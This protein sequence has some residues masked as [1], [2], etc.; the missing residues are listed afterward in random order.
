MLTL[1]AS[2]SDVGCRFGFRQQH[3]GSSP[4]FMHPSWERTQLWIQQVSSM[5]DLGSSRDVLAP[6]ALGLLES[7]PVPEL[8]ESLSNTALKLYSAEAVKLGDAV[9]SLSAAHKGSLRRV[10]SH[11]EVDLRHVPA[12]TCWTERTGDHEMALPG[13]L[14]TMDE[15][16]T[17][18]LV[19]PILGAG[20]HIVSFDSVTKAHF[21]VTSRGR[22]FTWVGTEHGHVNTMHKDVGIGDALTRM[23]PD[24][25]YLLRS[26]A[27][28]TIRAVACG[29]T[30]TV[31]LDTNGAVYT[32]GDGSTGALGHS[33]TVSRTT[34][35][36]VQ[37]LEGKRVSRIAAGYSHVLAATDV[38]TV[39]GTCLYAWGKNTHG[40]CGVGHTEPVLLPTPVCGMYEVTPLDV[41]A[42]Q[43]GSH[44]DAGPRPAR[45]SQIVVSAEQSLV[46]TTDGVIFRMGNFHWFGGTS[47]SALCSPTILIAEEDP[48]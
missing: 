48:Y 5:V 30:F 8:F 32:F 24:V 35:R 16:N 37:A 27:G 12:H 21:C 3:R 29:R 18:R 26:V 10:V 22:V 36:V 38:P 1:R 11:R 28:K 2:S 7:G 17:E 40:C 31:L 47:D 15:Q 4:D 23:T 20:E 13:Q 43:S 46:L 41:R 45:I 6:P 34:P 39:D 25:P 14:F 9:P 33:D 42:C 19:F 44:V